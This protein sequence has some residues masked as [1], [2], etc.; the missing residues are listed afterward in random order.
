M[1]LGLVLYL[2]HYLKLMESVRHFY[3]QYP[4]S[5]KHLSSLSLAGTGSEEEEQV[6]FKYFT[7]NHHIPQHSKQSLQIQHI[8]CDSSKYCL[9]QSDPFQPSSRPLS[10]V[11]KLSPQPITSPASASTTPTAGVDFS[12]P[13]GFMAR[14][15][16]SAAH[17]RMSVK[18]KNQRASTRGKRMPTVRRWRLKKCILP[19][20]EAVCIIRF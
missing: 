5:Q 6:I 4:E 13:A 12:S 14:L 1:S 8:I 7:N 20:H 10:P 3:L 2:W 18:P 19:S 11:S 16:N 15:N 9:I 17:H